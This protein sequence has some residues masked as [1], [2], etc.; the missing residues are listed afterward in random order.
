MVPCPA[1]LCP[2]PKT[3]QYV[4]NRWN[5]GGRM[6][7]GHG[8]WQI[9]EVAT[10][11]KCCDVMT[12]RTVTQIMQVIC[13]WWPEG[14]D[15]V[16][17]VSLV[18]EGGEVPDGHIPSDV[19]DEGNLITGFVCWILSP[20]LP[21]LMW[22]TPTTQNL[23]FEGWVG[24]MGQ[25]VGGWISGVSRSYLQTSFWFVYFLMNSR[26][27]RTFRNTFLLCPPQADFSLEHSIPGAD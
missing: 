16:W 13:Q 15:F 20:Y 27:L 10:A 9:F 7:S 2:K 17:C 25:C 23:K 11:V 18:N 21:H 19:A 6:P 1:Q 14:C 4:E 22:V 12:T 24:G 8:E 26:L 3:N 5:P